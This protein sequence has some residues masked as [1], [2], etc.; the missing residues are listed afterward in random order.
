MTSQ[1]RALCGALVLAGTVA[2]SQAPA[3]PASALARATAPTAPSDAEDVPD[4]EKLRRV[5]DALARMRDV[6]Q[7]TQLRLEEARRTRDVVKLNCVNDKLTQVKALLRI[8]EQADATLQ[9]A[10]AKREALT[11]SHAFTKVTIARQK[12]EQLRGQAG[13]CIG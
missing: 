2:F 1:W 3:T 5:T 7:D 8:S 13:A 12:V 9:E 11:A 4:T 10:I 6:F